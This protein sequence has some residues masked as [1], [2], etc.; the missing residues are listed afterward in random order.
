M[1]KDIDHDIPE[2]SI[3]VKQ[4]Q[5]AWLWSS[6]P[7]VIALAAL[8]YMGIIPEPMI[9]SILILI[10][11]IPRYMIWRTTAYILTD[12]ALIY[13]RGGITGSKKFQVPFTKIVEVSSRYGN[14]G[15]T[16]GYQVVDI[17]LDTGAKASLSYLPIPNDVESRILEHI[18]EYQ[19]SQ[20]EN[21]DPDSGDLDDS[22]QSDK[23]DT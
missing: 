8:F 14:F 19:E 3:I 7:W 15:R 23:S 18:T 9:A 6:M 1:D 4:V 21:S 16:L 2:N 12:E 11:A 10:I 5:Y 17:I 22:Q 20:E 13:Q